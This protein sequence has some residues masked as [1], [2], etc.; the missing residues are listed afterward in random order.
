MD[1]VIVTWT[2]AENKLFASL[3]AALPAVQF[4]S[5]D[6]AGRAATDLSDAAIFLRWWSP[7]QTS[8]RVFEQAKGLKWMHTPSAGLDQV[9]FPA[10]VESEVILTNSSGVHAI[11]IAE[12]VITY[13]LLAA[14][15][16][17]ELL[18]AQAEHRWA[19][20][21]KLQE[22]SDKTL[23]IVGYGAIGQEVAK[24][25]LPFGL[26]VIAA[27]SGSQQRAQIAGVELVSGARAWRAKLAEADYVAICLP[28]TTD[29]RHAF[30]APT[31][32]RMKPTAWLLNIA[33]GE[34]V[35]EDALLAALQ[36]GRIAGAALD[37]FAEEPLP[38]SHPLY[39]LPASRVILTPHLTWSSPHVQQRAIDLFIENYH[40]FAAGE[41]L[42]NVVDKRA[43]Y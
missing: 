13:I 2:L 26:R 16:V 36:E 19:D 28:L 38:S 15:R 40:R 4:I 12:W 39:S 8:E 10:L 35:D 9:L 42:R 7:K 23:L 21:L 41:Q 14:K 27:S 31:L 6:E 43:G 25:A 33:R 24:R 29:T 17:P 1:K 34:I 30:D 18:A 22:L 3:R 11:P 37:A 5:V 32:G 20:D